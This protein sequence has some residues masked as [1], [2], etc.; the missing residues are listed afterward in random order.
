MSLARRRLVLRDIL[1][2]RKEFN[3]V[4]TALTQTGNSYGKRGHSV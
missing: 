2:E 3:R 4:E 1:G